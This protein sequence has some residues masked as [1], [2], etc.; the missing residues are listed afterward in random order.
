MCLY[1][2]PTCLYE[3]LTCLFKCPTCPHLTHQ[4][5]SPCAPAW[6]LE[7]PVLS[8]DARKSLSLLSNAP[9]V[10][11]TAVHEHV[12][13]GQ[14]ARCRS[15]MFLPSRFAAGTFASNFPCFLVS[16]RTFSFPPDTARHWQPVKVLKELIDSFSYA[17][18]VSPFFVAHLFACAFRDLVLLIVVR[19]PSDGWLFSSSDRFPL[20]VDLAPRNSCCAPKEGD[21]IHQFSTNAT[22]SWVISGRNTGLGAELVQMVDEDDQNQASVTFVRSP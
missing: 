12:P 3:C 15:K 4:I 10:C 6:K 22:Y 11:W 14:N 2:C 17:K 8:K 20:L 21:V 19:L 18:I 7:M 16:L 1:K 9:C 5:L 13:G